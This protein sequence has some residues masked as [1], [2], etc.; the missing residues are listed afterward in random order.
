MTIDNQQERLLF[1]IGYI[2]GMIDSDGCCI[3]KAKRR[4]KNG[5]RHFTPEII[6]NN[7][8]YEIISKVKEA[9]QELNLP[10]HIW[11]PK[12]HGKEKRHI[13]R[14]HISG[15]KRIKNV[16]DILLEFPSGKKDRLQVLNDYCNYRLSIPKRIVSSG[17]EQSYS[18]V[19]EEFKKKLTLFNS[20]TKGVY[21]PQ[22]LYALH[23]K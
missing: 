23:Q 12:C 13:Y 15:I 8:D 4:L 18:K 11:E 16:T 22:R 7:T 3:L 9:L 5:I 6:I 1:Y 20:K 19:E 17:H 14:L 10:F 21:N 2:L